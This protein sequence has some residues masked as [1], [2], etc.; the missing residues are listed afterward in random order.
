MD[1]IRRAVRMGVEVLVAEINPKCPGRTV[2]HNLCD[3]V[4][5]AARGGG[6]RIARA[7]AG[8]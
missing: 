1:L 2:G 3:L 7:I 6:N 5:V 4:E 8:R